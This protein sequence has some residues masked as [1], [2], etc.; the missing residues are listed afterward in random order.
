MCQIK[1]KHWLEM[2]HSAGVLIVTLSL[3]LEQLTHFAPFV[4]VVLWPWNWSRQ[5]CKS[6]SGPVPQFNNLIISLL[7]LDG[8]VLGCNL[9]W[10]IC[11]NL[12][13][14]QEGQ[15]DSDMAGVNN[16]IWGKARRVC[17]PIRQ[18]R[19]T[20]AFRWHLVESSALGDEDRGN[21]Y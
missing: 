1:P 7:A 13:S 3:T 11:P 2:P 12:H 6:R 21:N 4:T 19:V 18:L 17:P 16:A 9:F 10:Q 5:I 15:S 14:L 20:I 8:G